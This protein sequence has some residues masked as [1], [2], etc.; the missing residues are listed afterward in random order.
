MREE[1]RRGSC[2]ASAEAITNLPVGSSSIAASTKKARR[3]AG[4]V[5]ELEGFEPSSKRG[6]NMLSTCLFACWFLWRGRQ[7]TANRAL[8]LLEFQIAREALAIL[9]P[10]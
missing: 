6:T 4:S 5:V 1:E 3:V 2:C 8:S 7:A 9:F 10:I